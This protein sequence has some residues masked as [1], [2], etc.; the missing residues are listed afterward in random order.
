MRD[1]A[2]RKRGRPKKVGDYPT[3]SSSTRA[4]T[5]GNTHEYSA[6]NGEAWWEDPEDTAFNLNADEE[7]GSAARRPGVTLG[8]VLM[9]LEAPTARTFDEMLGSD[10]H[11]SAAGIESID[12]LKVLSHAHELLD[13]DNNSDGSDDT[14][15]SDD[16]E[17]DE[18]TEF[19]SE[20]GDEHAAGTEQDEAADQSQS[21]K[22]GLH[23]TI[24]ARSWRDYSLE[25]DLDEK[26][27]AVDTAFDRLAERDLDAAFASAQATM[28][29]SKNASSRRR[30]STSS[31]DPEDQEGEP[32]GVTKIMRPPLMDWNDILGAKYGRKVKNVIKTGD[33]HTDALVKGQR[34]R[35]CTSTNATLSWRG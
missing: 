33:F 18:E 1:P 4:R 6:S 15:D 14:D 34:N 13:L 28:N 35:D 17:N 12:E 9:A 2:D 20:E 25:A 29:R 27:D 31:G 26:L 22:N 23:D 32:S 10:L 19:E 16:N 8:N 24:D 21:G 3:R 11:G 5:Y 30:Q 7:A